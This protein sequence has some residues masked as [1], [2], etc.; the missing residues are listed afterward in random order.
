M[1]GKG[2]EGR[3]H[4]PAQGRSRR[5]GRGSRGNSRGEGGCRWGYISGASTEEDP[6]H[7]GKEVAAADGDGDDGDDKWGMPH[8][9]GVG[10]AG[11]PKDGRGR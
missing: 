6:M 9:A 10:C 11:G 3:A 4:T 8:A 1:E 2:G 5:D 7:H